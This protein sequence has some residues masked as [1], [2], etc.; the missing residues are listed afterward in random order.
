[1]LT[2]DELYEET[3]WAVI[4][5]KGWIATPELLFALKQYT[6][7]IEEERSR[8]MAQTILAENS[9]G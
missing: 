1:M 9:D 4:D 7:E 3:A 6:K 8:V 2:P 5:R